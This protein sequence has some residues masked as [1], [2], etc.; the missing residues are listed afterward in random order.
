MLKPLRDQTGDA[1]TAK[2]AA[3]AGQ[4]RIRPDLVN[5]RAKLFLLLERNAELKRRLTELEGTGR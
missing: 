2:Q 3:E 1:L 5:E 4:E